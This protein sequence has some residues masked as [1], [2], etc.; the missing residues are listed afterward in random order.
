MGHLPTLLNS[1]WS[2]SCA[3]YRDQAFDLL[4]PKKFDAAHRARGDRQD[5]A[6][7]HEADRL[8][9]HIE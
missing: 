2:A 5:T 7:D 8:R 3:S 9:R 4:T 6:P 1:R